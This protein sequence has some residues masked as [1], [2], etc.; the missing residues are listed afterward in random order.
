MGGFDSLVYDYGVEMD[1]NKQRV[2]NINTLDDS[3]TLRYACCI[4]FFLKKIGF[5]IEYDGYLIPKNETTYRKI[6]I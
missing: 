5:D 2:G 4:F 3:E 6:F 1:G